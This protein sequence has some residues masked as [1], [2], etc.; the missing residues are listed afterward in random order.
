M[1]LKYRLNLS[2]ASQGSPIKELVADESR[3]LRRSTLRGNYGVDV[4]VVGSST[5]G[6]K[7]DSA[8]ACE[9]YALDI[10]Y[11]DSDGD[12]GR[13]V[14]FENGMEMDLR[15]ESNPCVDA[16][17]LTV[18]ATR[19]MP[20]CGE[21][22]PEDADD[23]DDDNSN[24]KKR[25]KEQNKNHCFKF[26]LNTMDSAEGLDGGGVFE[27]WYADDA[28]PSADE[29]AAGLVVLNALAFDHGEGSSSEYED[30]DDDE[31]EA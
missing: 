15:F 16:Y 1:G 10:H 11:W 2:R 30:W 25:N 14:I 20:R 24:Q 18:N 21:D 8:V 9:G 26:I 5:G 19:N 6:D 28:D 17:K 27:L 12:T 13:K 3:L 31:E 29:A 7:D 22:G 23:E 4:A